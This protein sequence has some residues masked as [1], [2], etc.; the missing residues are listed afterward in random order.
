M[1]LPLEDIRVLDLSRILTGPFCSMI[2]ADLGAEVIKVE[3]PG[4]GD[5]TRVWG[6]PFIKGESAYFL[7]LNR[8]KKSITLNLKNEKGREILYKLVQKCDVFLENFKPGVT[9]RLRMDYET[10]CKINPRIIYCSITGF[11]QS[12]PYRDYP[13]YDIVIQGMGGLMGITGEPDRPPVRIGVAITDIGAGMYAAIAILSAL[14][15]R[16][17]TKKGQWIDV[18]LL[19]STV[20]WMTYMAA[21]YFATG[22]V[23]KRMGSAHPNIVP[24]QCFKARDGKYLT[25]A[26]GN[27]RIW[28]NF[29]EA[30]GLE[31]MVEN[32]KFATNPKRVENR[33]ELIPVLE[34]AFLS[35]TR[36]EWIEILLKKGVPC[37]PVYTMD[38][39]FR[40]PQVLHRKMLVEIEHPKVGK[41]KQIGIPMKFSE[42]PGEIK[43][44]PPLLGQHTE[45]ILKN[46]LGYSEEEINQLRSEE[47]I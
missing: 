24:Y 16:E 42:T 41:I 6:P 36:D 46:L 40:D 5:D 30:L 11:G 31:N 27:D 22:M 34:K 12:G 8:N 33:D 3:M 10:I 18:S 26:V 15:A 32:P 29:C 39:V 2:L 21:N 28:K 45:E 9:K 7:C 14:I 47:V 13:A 19:D 43:V 35:K 1:V 25:V 38:E 37:G 17:K 23:P 4:R 44:P 20:S